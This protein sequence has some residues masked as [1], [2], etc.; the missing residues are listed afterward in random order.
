M[1]ILVLS[2]IH[3]ELGISLTLPPDRTADAYDVVVLAGDIHSPG[4]KAVY[5]AQRESIFGGK[6]VVLVPGNHRSVA[7]GR[8]GS[9]RRTRP[10]RSQPPHAR[11]QAHRCLVANQ[12]PAAVPRASPATVSVRR[13]CDALDRP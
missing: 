9:R 6:P 5:W 1:K 11:L 2:D 12:E 10:A 4:H 13:A 7:F 8:L 3:L